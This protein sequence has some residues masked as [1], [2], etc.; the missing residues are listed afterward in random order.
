MKLKSFITLFLCLFYLVSTAQNEINIGNKKPK[1]YERNS[2]AS[3]KRFVE[4]E[5][6]K[7]VGIIDCNEKLDYDEGSN[8]ILSKSSGSAFTGRCESCFQN[9]TLERRMN[10]VNGKEEGPDT[11]Y[12][13]TSC[14][15]VTR[16][17]IYG[18][19]EG[20][21]TYYYDSTSAIAWMMNYKNGMKHGQQVFLNRKGDTT[22]FENYT[23]GI[24]NGIKKTYYKE[25]KV[26]KQVIYKNGL[27][28][29]QFIVY[30]LD[31]KMLQSVSYKAGKKN[32]LATYFYDDGTLLRTENWV[33]DVKNG[34]FKT[35][36]YEGTVQTI[37]NYKKGLKEGWFEDRFYDQKLK[38]RALYKKDI[39][40]EEHIYDM[41]GKE[42]ST[43]GVEASKDV[44]DDAMPTTGKAKK[45]KKTKKPKK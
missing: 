20:L 43:F 4:W 25:S 10:F 2:S 6:G 18:K 33:M 44:E 19:E 27:L 22:S 17:H 5:C 12:Y 23:D 45:T 42:I 8:T 39:L 7:I 13:K 37:E 1:C 9:G 32:G 3:G 11:T 36:Y 29:G 14:L 16:N 28:D 40:I 35:L 31:Q 41:Y 15:M 30:N 38:R 26:E 21:W 34:E 24:L